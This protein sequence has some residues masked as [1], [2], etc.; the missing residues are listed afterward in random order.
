VYRKKR[1][2]QWKLKNEKELKQQ[3]NIVID[4]LDYNQWDNYLKNYLRMS[5]IGFQNLHELVHPF[6]VRNETY[7]K[8][9]S[10]SLI[11]TVKVSTEENSDSD[12]QN[13]T[14]YTKIWI[15]AKS[16]EFE[17][18]ITVFFTDTEYNCKTRLTRIYD[19]K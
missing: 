7:A 2:L 3:T 12:T 8:N 10:G 16:C 9:S 19:S 11:S 18:E 13:Q 6:L 4:Y 17:S 5:R 1:E 15:H 14:F